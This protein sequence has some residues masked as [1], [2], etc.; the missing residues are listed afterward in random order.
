MKEYKTNTK[1]DESATKKTA[2][3]KTGETR[4][5]STNLM[6]I[7]LWLNIPTLGTAG[8]PVRIK[9]DTVPDRYMPTNVTIA[10]PVSMQGFRFEVN[11]ETVRARIVVDYTYPD[12]LVY[13]RDDDQGGPRPTV[14]QLPGLK[15]DPASHTV[16]YEDNRKRT[17]CA[18]VK[19]RGGILRHHLRVQNTGSCFA[20]AEVV[21]HAED[22]GWKV[23]RVRA[24]D[25]YF[26]VH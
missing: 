3:K 23:R 14:A 26:E 24:I 19:E 2:E 22:D 20:T 7:V 1:A 4:T 8:T 25:T 9:I 13:Q 6:W 16:V 10:E 21:R 5:R 12:E 18:Y 17:V 15:Y 11:E